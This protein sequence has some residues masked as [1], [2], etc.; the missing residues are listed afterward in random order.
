M[1]GGN[2]SVSYIPNCQEVY[3]GPVPQIDN[4]FSIGSTNVTYRGQAMYQ[5][6]A[7]FAFPTGQP[8]ERISCLS[9][10]RWEKKPNC[11]GKYKYVF[12]LIEII[13]LFLA[14]QCAALP[15]VQHVNVTILNGL[16]RSYG[17]IVRYECEP[18]YIRSGPPVILCMSNG[19]WSGEVPVCARKKN[20][21]Q[22]VII[23]LF[24]H[25]SGAKCPDFPVIKNG[26]ITDNSRSYYYNDEARVQ[27]FKGFKLIGNSI[28]RCGENQHFNNPPRCEDIN[29]CITSQCDVAS[30][31]CVNEGGSFYCKCRKGFE[32]TLECRP[33]GDLGLMNGGIPD[34]S[35]TVSSSEPGYEKSV[36]LI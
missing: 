2:W 7:G 22:F 27:C 16:G 26:F 33:V 31:E 9:D 36:S 14:S 32:P 18:G 1:P 25:I 12:S 10:G 4:G 3:C 11:L 15:D 34:E 23:I 19:T 29:E 35:I 28:L 6:Y 17:T 13:K 8:I 24:Y 20:V 30:T 21:Y 5:C